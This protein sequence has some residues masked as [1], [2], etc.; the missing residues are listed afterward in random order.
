MS[1]KGV[2]LKLKKI[3]I[4]IKKIK[5]ILVRGM[6]QWTVAQYFFADEAL[7]GFLC[8]SLLES[9]TGYADSEK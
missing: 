4:K 3:K 1:R 5:I 2:R 6:Q 7:W 9:E 8:T